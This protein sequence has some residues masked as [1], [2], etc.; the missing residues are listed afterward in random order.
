VEIVKC[1]GRQR[2]LGQNEQVD[3]LGIRSAAKIENAGRIG[4]DVADTGEG[5]PRADAHEA[6]RVDRTKRAGTGHSG[7]LRY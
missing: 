6:M 1:I 3:P 5:R 2:Q 4:R 7:L